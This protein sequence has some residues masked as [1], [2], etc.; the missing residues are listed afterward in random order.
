MTD[1]DPIAPAV[2]K[3]QEWIAEVRDVLGARDRQRGY[4]ALR[5]TLH[6]LRDR[7]PVNETAH[8]GAQ[9]PMVIRGIYY[10]GWDPGSTRRAGRSPDSFFEDI[11]QAVPGMLPS[12]AT[13]AARAA[14]TVL[15]R[16]VSAGEIDDVRA[17]LSA[18][19]RRLWPAN[20]NEE[21]D[22]E[23]TS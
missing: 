8:L 15:T 23:P 18:P 22:D 5:A 16:H 3:A 6:A 11:R 13:D 12:E 19:L 10:E 1:Q 7:L 14:L 20:V 2:H 17:A 4:Q 9:L 21:A